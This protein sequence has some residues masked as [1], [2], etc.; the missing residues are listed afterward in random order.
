MHFC[1]VPRIFPLRRAYRLP[2]Y[3]T[4]Y[5][6]Q[7]HETQIPNSYFS[8]TRH[9]PLS[10][11]HSRFHI[12][13]TRGLKNSMICDCDRECNTYNIMHTVQYT[14]PLLSD[15]WRSV[16]VGFR[17]FARIRRGNF[18]LRSYYRPSFVIYRISGYDKNILH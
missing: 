16:F 17:W 6:T 9:H 13:Y 1:A 5:F 11:P 8:S 3:N 15:K 7:S 2:P 14:I 18:V 10:H 4:P 12:G